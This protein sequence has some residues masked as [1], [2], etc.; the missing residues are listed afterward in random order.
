MQKQHPKDLEILW[1]CT[2]CGTS[3]LYHSDI[4]EHKSENNH[5]N[6]AEFDLDTGKI[7]THYTQENKAQ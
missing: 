7:L 4:E 5:R 1:V 6:V 2:D 3:S